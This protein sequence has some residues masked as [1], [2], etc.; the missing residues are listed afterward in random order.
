MLINII[1]KNTTHDGLYEINTGIRRLEKLMK[2]ERW[3]DKKTLKV[4]KTDKFGAPSVCQ[5]INGTDGSAVAPFRE[6][7]DNFYIYSSDIC[8]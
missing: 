1:Q 5:Y 8:R 7:N 4:W 6:K 2:I 3:N